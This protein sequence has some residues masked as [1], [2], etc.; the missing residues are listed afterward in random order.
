MSL[1]FSQSNEQIETTSEQTLSPEE[2]ARLEQQQ[3]QDR[4]RAQV[5]FEYGADLYDQ[6]NYEAAI[7]AWRGALELSGEPVIHYNI[8]N[9][10]ERL[11]NFEEAIEHNQAYLPHASSD[12]IATIESRIQWLETRIQ[13]Q[14]EEVSETEEENERLRQELEQARATQN[15]EQTV[16]LDEQN[17]Q[18]GFST[19]QWGLLALSGVGFGTGITLGLVTL[20]D[21][22]RIEEECGSFNGNIYCSNNAEVLIYKEASHAMISDIGFAGGIITAII[23]AVTVVKNRS[24]DEQTNQSSFFLRPNI[25]PNSL[26]ISLVGSF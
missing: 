18:T 16:V 20:S 15:V 12:E 13:H 4:E 24:S 19:I 6:G 8:A 2:E 25:E 22:A 9:A 11:G 1:G 7:N 23:F 26:G 14:E 17:T 3:Q 5:M 10:F 21:R